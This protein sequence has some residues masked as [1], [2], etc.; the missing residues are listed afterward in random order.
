M[1][2]Q[3]RIW[4]VSSRLCLLIFGGMSF[5]IPHIPRTLCRPITICFLP[6]IASQVADALTTMMPSKQPCTKLDRN[7]FADGILKLITQYE[8]CFSCMGAYVEK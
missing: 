3:L 2:T 6:S 1:T 4:L 7:F 5:S 8:K